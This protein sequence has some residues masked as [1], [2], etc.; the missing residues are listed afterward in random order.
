MNILKNAKK[1]ISFG[2]FVLAIV[3]LSSCNR[4]MGCPTFS[5]ENSV[6]ILAQALLPSL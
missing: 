5:V 1:Q 3:T 6:E 4:G 2:I